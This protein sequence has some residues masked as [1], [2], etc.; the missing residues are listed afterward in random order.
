MSQVTLR[1]SLE[2]RLA[3]MPAL[4]TSYENVSYEPVTNTPFQR[5]NLLPATPDNSTLGDAHYIELGI[6]QVTLCYPKNTGANAA[7]ARAE[8][9]K[10]HFPRG[11]GLTEGAITLTIS[12]TPAIAPAYVNEAFYCIP[13]SIQYHAHIN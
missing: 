2:T 3:L 5:V 11:L 10:A 9:V 4:A 6:F 7:Q 13:V 1:K 12:R 8:L